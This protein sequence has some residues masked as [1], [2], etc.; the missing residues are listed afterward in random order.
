M[1]GEGTYDIERQMPSTGVDGRKA[2]AMTFGVMQ[3]K[4]SPACMI[5]SGELRSNTVSNFN[6]INAARKDIFEVMRKYDV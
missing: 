2:W 5:G 4:A 6:K 3:C 1:A